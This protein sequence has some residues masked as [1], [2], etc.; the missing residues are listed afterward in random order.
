MAEIVSGAKELV[1][2]LKAK[3]AAVDD[4]VGRAVGIAALEL[5]A[6]VKKQFTTSHPAGTPSPSSPGSPPSV[7]T[8]SLRR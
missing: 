3:A 1:A 7:V 2:A 4:G 6:T 8:G 5:E